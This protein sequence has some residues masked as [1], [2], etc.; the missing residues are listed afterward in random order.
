MSANCAACHH[1]ESFVADITLAHRAA[2]ITCTDCHAEHRG[3]AFRPVNAALESCA[4]CHNDQNKNLYNGKTVHTAHGGTYGYPVE[5]GIWIWSGLDAEELATKPEI[6]TLL[7]QNGVT[8]GQ[9]QQWRRA[10][11]HAI[12][13]YRVRI[14]GVNETKSIAV[15]EVLPCNTC[16]KNGLLGANVDRTA[17][18]RC[19]NAQAFY[20]VGKGAETPSCISCHV[21]H[22]RDTHWTSILLAPQARTLSSEGVNE[23]K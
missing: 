13:W 12:H 2:G 15:T 21:Q 6:A 9:T 14:S 16:H 5:N 19:H 8:P 1:T 10:Q 23:S 17:C 11:F 4:K 7:K 18:A 22:I 3:A 20:G